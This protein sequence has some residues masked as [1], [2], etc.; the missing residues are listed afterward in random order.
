[1]IGASELTN[2]SR[3]PDHIHYGVVCHL[4]A[5]VWYSLPDLHTKF[6]NLNFREYLGP[7]M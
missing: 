5:N 3:D 1:M 6:D 2:G 4:K 7:K